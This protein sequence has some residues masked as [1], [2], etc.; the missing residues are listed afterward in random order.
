MNSTNPDINQL[1]QTWCEATTQELE[2]NVLFERYWLEAIRFGVTNDDVKL[3]VK[4]RV[5]WN[6]TNAFKKSLSFRFVIGT[7][8]GLAS[9]LSEA[10]EERTKLRVRVMPKG[11]AAVLRATGRSPVEVAMEGARP[12]GEVIEALRKAVNA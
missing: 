9:L 2:L 4:H 8:D 7:E 12:I 6:F 3:C 11:K 5:S 1:H 10:A